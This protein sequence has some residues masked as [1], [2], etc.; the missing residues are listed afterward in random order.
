[1]ITDITLFNRY[2]E[3]HNPFYQRTYLYKVDWDRPRLALG[4]PASVSVL[5]LIPYEQTL[6][7]RPIV[8]WQKSR[9]GYWTLQLED[10][11]VNGIVDAQIDTVTDDLYQVYSLTDLKHAFGL[12]TI[13]DLY[14]NSKSIS[15]QA[16][17]VGAH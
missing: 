1:M 15:Q 4:M 11:I 2:V 9:E 7:Y 16:F 12:V 13:T 10:V 14:L 5:I 6:L 17:Q 3:G 8:E